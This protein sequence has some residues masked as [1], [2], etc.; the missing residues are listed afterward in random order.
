MTEVPPQEWLEGPFAGA[1]A[2]SFA[3]ATLTPVAARIATRIGFVDRPLPPLKRHA[4]P[5]PYLGGLAVFLSF[6]AARVWV[7][8][9]DGPARAIL[10]G[11][12][13]VVTVGLIDDARPLSPGQKLWGQLWAATALVASGARIEL[14]MIPAP[15]SYPLSV[16]WLVTCMNAFNVLDVSDGLATSAAMVGS[17]GAVLVGL[18][19]RDSTLAVTGACVGGAAAAFLFMNRPPARIYL[20]DAGAMFFGA[21]IGAL[22]ML[23]RY[24]AT[25][26]VS[27]YFVPLTL[28]AVPLFELTLVVLARAGA[29]RAVYLGS[30]DHVALRL[31]HAGWSAGR[32]VAASLLAGLAAM[33]AG[34][35]S[36]R[37]SAPV[38]F[39]LVAATVL[40]G[41]TLLAI[42]LARF[43]PPAR[44]S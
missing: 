22:A 37:A 27:P 12:A 32:V 28:V 7:R 30:G 18:S 43:P 38:A 19:T 36:I 25:N 21:T 2:S 44:P 11:S 15:L 4:Q 23:A 29:R 20:G 16:L 3:A 1:L 13:L 40:A 42:V 17:L 6:T 35:G 9:L 31:K 5:V 34:I 24:G 39:G 41:G 26:P 33:A 8:P 14:T 10:I